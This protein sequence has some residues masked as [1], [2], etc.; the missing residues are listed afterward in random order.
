LFGYELV[1]GKLYDVRQLGRCD[2]VHLLVVDQHL[3]RQ[4]FQDPYVLEGVVGC[5]SC[6]GVPVEA[7][8]NE[9]CEVRI[10][11][12]NDV[13]EGLAIRF[14]ILAPGILKHDRV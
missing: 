11:I 14:S 8:N 3:R 2:V 6:V 1:S 13:A 12:A 10:F 9:I 7:L 5:K 4:S